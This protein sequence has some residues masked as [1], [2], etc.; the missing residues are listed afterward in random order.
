MTRPIEKLPDWPAAMNREWALAYSGVAE[1][2]MREWQKRGRVR[3][4]PRGPHG[5]MLC[6]RSD[7]DAALQEMFTAGSPEDLDFA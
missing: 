3:F 2:Q 6:L 5:A 4:Q 7:V 1:A